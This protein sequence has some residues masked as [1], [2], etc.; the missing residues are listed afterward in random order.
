M[1]LDEQSTFL[2][3]ATPTY[4]LAFLRTLSPANC[5][6]HSVGWEQPSLFPTTGKSEAH[7]NETST[8]KL[9][10]ERG[11]ALNIHLEFLPKCSASPAKNSIKKQKR[12][13]I[14]LL[15][16]TFST[17]SKYSDWAEYMVSELAKDGLAV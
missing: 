7:S 17:T 9:V 1:F 16:V 15:Q 3:L 10:S 6:A 14:N 5:K 4:I 11:T 2:P 12:I 8:Y 13:I